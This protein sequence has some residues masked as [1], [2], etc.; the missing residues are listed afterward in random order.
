MYCMREKVTRC[1][2]AV[3]LSTRGHAAEA[4]DETKHFHF[5]QSQQKWRT[6]SGNKL[7]T[8]LSSPVKVTVMT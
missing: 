1:V 2:L 4:V 6:S 3:T 5:E 7:S 8:E